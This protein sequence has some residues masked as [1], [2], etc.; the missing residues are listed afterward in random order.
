[1]GDLF[2]QLG[3][4]LPML[5]AQAVNFV[6]LLVVLTLFVY[7]PLMKAI[8]ERR[9]KIE[10]GIS[11]AE[12]AEEKLREAESLKEEKLREA[13]IV[14]MKIVGGAEAKA[15]ARGQE[16]VS[17]AIEKGENILKEAEQVSLRR[18]TEEL[19]NLSREA[20]QIV[21]EAISQAV[22]IDP[23]EVDKKLITQAVNLIKDKI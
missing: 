21:K 13:D 12:L 18:R 17:L 5:I 15:N 22:A 7:K 11:G 16:I 3:I 14:A 10:F 4:N 20:A 23:L 8:E 9:K 19:D 1:M 6:V 2:G